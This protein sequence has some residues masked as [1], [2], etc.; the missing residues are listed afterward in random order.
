[1]DADENRFRELFAAVRRD[2]AAAAPPFHSSIRPRVSQ[3][4]SVRHPAWPWIA[5]GAFASIVAVFFLVG[6]PAENGATFTNAEDWSVICEWS[7]PSDTF[8]TMSTTSW[9]TP[10]WTDQWLSDPGMEA[11]ENQ[12]TSL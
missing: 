11:T 6:H 7:A 3:P 8:L 9:N 2:D 5:A 10:T 12:A 4:E 1:M